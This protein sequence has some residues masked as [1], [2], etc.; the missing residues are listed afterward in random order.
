MDVAAL[1]CSDS[2]RQHMPQGHGGRGCDR[3]GRRG[4]TTRARVADM[5][6]RAMS[7]PTGSDWVWEGVR[8]SGG[9]GADRQG[10]QHGTAGAVLNR[11][12]PVQTDSNLPK[13]S[14][15]QKVPSRAPKIGKKIWLERG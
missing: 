6:D 5:W 3:G 14:L 8:G 15:I 7:G 9:D 10:R 13:F 12:K 1:G 4:A 11:F 2:D